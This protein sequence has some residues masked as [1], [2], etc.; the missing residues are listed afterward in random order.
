MGLM[1][2]VELGSIEKQSMGNK[3]L[4]V[5]R[6]SIMLGELKKGV[7]LKETVLSKEFGISR[8][9]IR[10]AIVELEN[11]GLVSTPA[12]GRTIV[13]GFSIKDIENLY[14]TRI[15]IES[16]AISE[17]T[18]EDIKNG[19]EKLYYYIELMEKGRDIGRSDV[20]SDLLFHY[21]LIEL[22]GNK[23]LM[24]L[25]KSMNGLITTLINVTTDFTVPRDIV[26]EHLKIVEYLEAGENEKAKEKNIKHVRSAQQFYIQ[27]V[28]MLIDKERKNQ[29]E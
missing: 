28:S 13:E 2:M 22:T 3:V 14:D 19:K 26:D 7:H 24:Q 29:E 21:S 11:E 15:L 10:E 9:P 25:W 27:A 20:E 4:E 18:K 6:K 8:G 5:L 1:K 12:N 23:T 16:Y 17:I